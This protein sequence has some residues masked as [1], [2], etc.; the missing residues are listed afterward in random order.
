V[1]ARTLAGAPVEASITALPYDSELQQ[2]P[3]SVQTS[4]A[5]GVSPWVHHLAAT[6]AILSW[7]AGTAAV[8][9]FFRPPLA[10]PYAS[11]SL[12]NSASSAV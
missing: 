1:S 11:I 8:R 2:A 7:P 12:R 6:C 3:L 4:A 10:D 5:P 9:Y